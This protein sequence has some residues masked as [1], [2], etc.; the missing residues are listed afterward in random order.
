[1][2]VLSLLAAAVACLGCWACSTLPRSAIPA[3]DPETQGFRNAI[4]RIDRINSN[5][6]SALTARAAYVEVLARGGVAPCRQRLDAAQ[7]QLDW[8]AASPAAKV[9]FPDGWA[10]T[11]DDEYRV[12]SSRAACVADAAARSQDLQAARAAA[13]RAVALYLDVFDYRSAVIMQFNVAVTERRLGENA[14]ALAALRAAIGMDR[15]YG[16]RADAADNYRQLLSWQGAPADGQRVA[17]LMQDFPHRIATLRFAWRAGDATVALK[18]LHVCLYQ[19]KIIDSRGASTLERHI[20]PGPDGWRVTSVAEQGSYDPGVWPRGEN[21]ALMPVIV[22]PALLQFPGVQIRRDGQFESV[23]EPDAFAA[24]LAAETDRLVRATVPGNRPDH[25]LTDGDLDAVNVMLAPQVI[26]HDVTENYDLQTG[27]WIG[28][29]LEQGV[30]YSTT[31]PLSLP[32]Q[33]GV[34]VNQR[35]DFVYTRSLPC[36]HAATS[37][38][39]VELVVRATPQPAALA[40]LLGNY[41]TERGAPMHYSSSMYLRLVVDPTSMLP[42]VRDTHSYWQLGNGAN[43]VLIASERMVSTLTYHGQ[44]HDRESSTLRPTTPPPAHEV[45]PRLSCLEILSRSRRAA[46]CCNGRYTAWE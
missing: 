36:T 9:M 34:I 23:S 25:D 19:G 43:D 39:C 8:L 5:L 11:A 22:P 13:L 33:P 4:A 30:W 6:P 27:L 2:T 31:A 3:G 14:A 26:V 20:R 35:L 32:G 44:T 42:Y 41:R 15:E 1:M 37:P 38:T 40:A 29:S 24:R 17:A 16:F 45:K 28:A 21:N 7:A 10:R 46:T 18:V 12:Q